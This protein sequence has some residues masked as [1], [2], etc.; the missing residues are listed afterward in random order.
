M[1]PWFNAPSFVRRMPAIALAATLAGCAGGN[2]SPTPALTPVVTAAPPTAT[3][4]PTP[5]PDPWPKVSKA[6]EVNGHNLYLV[7]EG[8]GPTTVVYLHGMGGTMNNAS[9]IAA[10]LRKDVRI[11]RYD[12]ANM[13]ESGSV[14]GKQT[15]A[16]AV[17]DL[18]ALLS[19]PA[20]SM[21][22]RT[23]RSSCLGRR[24]AVWSPTSTR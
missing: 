5:T 7:C 16:N 3:P 8:P 15:A 1:R 22:P 6:F 2:P 9:L 21:R 20:S 12:R 4:A 18:H 11:C 10:N 24:S 19:P 14:E 23:T 17:A 13:G